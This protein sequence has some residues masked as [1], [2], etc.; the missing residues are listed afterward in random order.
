MRG[1]T[2]CSGTPRH[3]QGTSSLDQKC[4]LLSPQHAKVHIKGSCLL[5]CIQNPD[6][7]RRQSLNPS[8]PH[9]LSAW[10]YSESG[11]LV[12]ELVFLPSLSAEGHKDPPPTGSIT[13]SALCSQEPAGQRVSG[14]AKVATIL[15]LT[16]PSK[17]QNPKRYTEWGEGKI[18]S[19]QD[20]PLAKKYKGQKLSSPSPCHTLMPR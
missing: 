16:S 15:S 5:Q 3:C 10:H 19:F 7:W 12:P 17:L 1:C 20:C 4:L 14:G 18:V 8:H 13:A 6:V 2:V 9:W 11:L